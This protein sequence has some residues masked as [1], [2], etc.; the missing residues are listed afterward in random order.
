MN[1]LLTFEHPWA[2]LMLVPAVLII[3]W[4]AWSSRRRPTLKVPAVGPMRLLPRTAAVRLGWLPQV[5]GGLALILSAFALAR[6]QLPLPQ[7]R[8]VSVEGIDI[9]VSLDLSTSMNAADFK[10]HNRFYVAKQVLQDFVKSRPSDRV[11]LVVF[12]ADAFTQCP[13]TLDHA[14]LMNIIESLKLGVIEDGTAIGNGLAMALNRLRE[15]QAK[16][17]VVILITDGDNNSGNVSPLEAANMAKELGVRV[18]TILVGRGGKV[19]YPAKDIFGQTTYVD[20]EIPTNPE[21]LK[22]IAAKADGSFY[23]AT[24]GEALRKSLRDILD[25]LEK[26]RLF[27]AAGE[28][29][30]D[31]LFTWFLTPALAFAFLDFFLRATRLRRFP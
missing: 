20:M 6:P 18:Y 11:G 1:R 24:D 17:R 22:Q 8:D 2:L 14:V 21:L 9:V 26:T 13:L 3:V 19:P 31:E 29:K 28:S 4:R 30:K 7:A 10:P 27:E 5:F 12:A 23:P 15:S 25:S 16:S